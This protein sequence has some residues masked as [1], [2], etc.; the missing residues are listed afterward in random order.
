[1]YF[2]VF[3]VLRLTFILAFL[4]CDSKEGSHLLHYFLTA[5][6]GT[7]DLHF[8]MLRHSHRECKFFL[9]VRALV[10]VNRHKFLL[11]ALKRLIQGVR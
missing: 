1:L 4:G 10:I 11:S 6:L 2:I 9:T 5:A 7:F 3:Y 8:V